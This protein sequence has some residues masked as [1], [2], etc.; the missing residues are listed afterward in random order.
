MRP[1]AAAL[2]VALHAALL[3]L[4]LAAAPR[5]PPPPARHRHTL[6]VADIDIVATHPVADPRGMHCD[7]ATSYVG[8][9]AEIDHYENVVMKVAAGYPAERAGLR[10]GDVVP[11]IGDLDS[12]GL[13]HH[14]A[15]APA[16]ITLHVL[17]AGHG[18]TFHI[19]SGTICA[20][21]RRDRSSDRP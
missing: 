21:Q 10:V 3:A 6:D 16:V 5:R 15:N 19:Q 4:L 14:G 17:R 13:E 18:M 2:S 20:E 12:I 9:G 11:D 8:I 1:A 7:P